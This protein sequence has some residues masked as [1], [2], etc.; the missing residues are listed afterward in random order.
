MQRQPQPWFVYILKCSDS[1]FYTGCSTDVEAR[2]KVHNAGKGAKYTR[3]R[4]PCYVV[5]QTR[6]KG[7]SEALKLEHRIKRLT[8]AKKEALIQESLKDHV[9]SNATLH[10]PQSS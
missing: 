8:R 4:R 7:R 5:Y 3:P 1:T 9:P 10:R 2:A 6:C